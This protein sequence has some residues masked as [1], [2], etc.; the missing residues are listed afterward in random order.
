MGADADV[1]CAW[2]R[3]RFPAGDFEDQEGH[4]LVHVKGVAQPHTVSGIALSGGGGSSGPGGPPDDPAGDWSHR[5][6]GW[7]AP[8]DVPLD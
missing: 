3:Q 6:G 7:S 4:G 2:E 1:Y 8:A 5:S